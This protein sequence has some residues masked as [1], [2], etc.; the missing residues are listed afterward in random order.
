[1]VPAALLIVAVFVGLVGLN[2]YMYDK[3]QTLETTVSKILQ[4][5]KID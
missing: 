4:K 5:V 3:V 2:L 1:M